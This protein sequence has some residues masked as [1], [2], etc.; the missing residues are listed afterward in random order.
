V[1]HHFYALHT[2]FI[3]PLRAQNSIYWLF[4]LKDCY[5]CLNISFGY[6]IGCFLCH[7]PLL[8]L[9]IGLPALKSLLLLLLGLLNSVDVCKCLLG[10]ERD[11]R[12]LL[13]LYRVEFPLLASYLS[14]NR[15][16]FKVK[17]IHCLINLL[18]KGSSWARER[19][20]CYQLVDRFAE[21]CT[22]S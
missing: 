16:L 7:S 22:I 19:F 13:Q 17:Y 1:T 20:N 6:L 4:E 14:A 8:A 5:T 2:L 15:C 3:H 21:L 10:V 9:R 12:T 18:Q 11:L